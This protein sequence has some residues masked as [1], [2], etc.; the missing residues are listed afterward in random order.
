MRVTSAMNKPDTPWPHAP[1]H[2]L[3]E[4]GTYFITAAT[5]KKEHFFRG[6]ERLEVLHRGLLTV[7]RDYG[8]ILEAWAVFSNHYHFVG[9]SPRDQ[10]DATS[11]RPMLATLHEKM[12]KW[13]NKLDASP[14]RKVWHNWRDSRLTY[15]RS[16]LARLA[17]THRNAVKHGIVPVA[18]QYPWCSA[19]WFEREATPAQQK[20]I[21]SFGEARIN[22]PD[23]YP[24][25]ND[26]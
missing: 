24:S 10:K 15:E 23:D 8:W 4:T 12:A 19:R 2:I 6:R 9:K 14:G 5:Y 17:Y 18:N 22:V 3:G 26:Y 25:D 16:Y 7:A 21:Y 1:S 11:L 20:T 13:V